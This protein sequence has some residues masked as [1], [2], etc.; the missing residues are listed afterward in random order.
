MQ[1]PEPV[2]LSP[3]SSEKLS[4]EVFYG[5]VHLPPPF[6]LLSSPLLWE[7]VAYFAHLGK[8]CCRDTG[9]RTQS[10]TN[11]NRACCR[12]TMSR[13]LHVAFESSVADNT[14]SFQLFHRGA[15]VLKVIDLFD[16]VAFHRVDVNRHDAK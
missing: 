15:P 11:P 1:F 12:Y 16:M 14:L 5:R 6:G 9:I 10:R 8:I 7:T 3:E 13:R 4:K 2:F